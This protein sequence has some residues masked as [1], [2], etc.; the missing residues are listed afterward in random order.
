V[1]ASKRALLVYD[2]DCG[3]CVRFKRAVEFLDPRG[4]LGFASIGQAEDLGLLDAMPDQ[5]RHSSFHLI[6]SGEDVESGAGA[7]PSLVRMLP[8]GWLTS[9]MLTSAP[10]GPRA[11]AWVYSTTARLHG[12]ACERGSPGSETVGTEV[13]MA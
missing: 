3:S 11:T 1:Q 9:K 5:R 13:T 7:L 6:K 12:R 4:L 2:I 8:L 10:G